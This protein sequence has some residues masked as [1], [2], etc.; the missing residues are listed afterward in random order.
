MRDLVLD[1]SVVIK[2]F[3]S[4]QRGSP[5]AHKLLNDYQ[6][7]EFS[8]VV[9]SLFF[10]EV[11]NVAGRGWQWD[12]EA[13]MQL[14]EA[15]GNLSFEVAEPALLTVAHW[16]SLGLTAYDAAYVALAEERGLLL[17]TDDDKI[18]EVAT[19]ISRALVQK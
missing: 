9:P 3:V 1:A 4:E 19:A 12:G 15:L 14:A 7:G 17:V 6:A 10:L 13:V 8:V 11:L 18:I 5:E 2:W 16:V